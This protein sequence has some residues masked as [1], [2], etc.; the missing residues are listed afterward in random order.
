M[1]Y[2]QQ[3]VKIVH[4]STTIGM[5]HSNTV[6]MSKT[7]ASSEIFDIKKEYICNNLN[8]LTNYFNSIKIV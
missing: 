5:E 2:I 8:T 7:Q 1:I 3:N 4:V 6:L